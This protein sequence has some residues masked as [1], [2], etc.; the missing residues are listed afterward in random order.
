MKYFTIKLR[1]N[2]DETHDI[3]YAKER[4]LLRQDL[5]KKETLLFKFCRQSKSDCL[6]ESTF[7]KYKRSKAKI[8]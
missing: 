7:L 6:I 8:D 2:N 3:T 5:K 1:K 4:R